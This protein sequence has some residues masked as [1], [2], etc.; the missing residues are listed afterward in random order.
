MKLLFQIL[1]WFCVVPFSIALLWFSL[2]L[3]FGLKKLNKV[4][5]AV[6]A[7]DATCAVIMPAHNEERGISDAVTALRKIAPENVRI[8]VVADNCDDATAQLAVAAGA[9]AIVRKD[10]ELRGKGFALA[11]GRDF[12]AQDPPDAVVVL[13]ADCR[14]AQGS[15]ETLVA[16][17]LSS[18]R[19]AQA[20]DV[21]SPDLSLQPLVQISSFAF[22]VKNVARLRGLSRLGGCSVLC[23]TGMAFPWRVFASA[24]LAT[25]NVVEDLGLA[26]TLIRQGCLPALVEDA[27]VTS[28]AASFGESIQQR[29]RWELGFLEMARSAA[30][31]EVLA[32]LRLRNRARFSLG[33]HLL[34]PPVALLLAVSMIALVPAAVLS[35]MASQWLPGLTLA[36]LILLAVGLVGT[37]WI[38]EGRQTLSSRVLIRG[39]LYVLWKIPIYLGL[40]R[41]SPLD[42][43]RTGR[44]DS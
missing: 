16:A 11:F 4:A 27:L 26:I 8:I 37:V 18:G 42:W 9:E 28:K 32:G 7:K 30:L 20:L 22:L 17:A 6:P 23:G 13:D 24:P 33:M 44:G 21:I 1:A 38:R 43:N 29:R 34:V 25:G 14:L 15:I 35:W 40:I 10:A 12:L 41:R 19:P 2:E 5:S 36:T 3:V 31:P 39:P